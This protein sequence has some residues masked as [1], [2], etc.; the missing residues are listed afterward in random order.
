MQPIAQPIKIHD[1]LNPNLWSNKKLRP[2]IRAGLLRIAKEFY[3]FLKVN[4]PVKDILITGSQANYTYTEFSDIDLHLVFD[5]ASISC[6]EPIEELFDTKRKLWNEQHN[7]KIYDIPVELYAEDI[8]KIDIKSKSKYS[9]VKDEWIDDPDKPFVDYNKERVQELAN[10]WSTAITYAIKTQNLELCDQLKD[11]LS[12]F[13]KRS[14]KKNGEFGV[15]NLTFKALRNSG[16]IKELV[17]T[18]NDLKDES[19]SID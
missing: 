5:Y 11:L 3:K 16:L 10:A 12:L 19:L 9:L 18:I 1:E 14:L 13:R 15:G 4:T 17:D 6:D 7:I 2:E 8:V